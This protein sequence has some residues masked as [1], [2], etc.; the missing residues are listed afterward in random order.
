MEEGADMMA[1][2]GE[3]RPEAGE[4]REMTVTTAQ[5]AKEVQ[6]KMGAEG[7]EVQTEAAGAM[8]AHL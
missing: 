6:R 7:E 5:E 2:M 4:E 8:E 1:V 3:R